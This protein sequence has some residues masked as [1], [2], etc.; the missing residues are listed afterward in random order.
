MLPQQQS[1]NFYKTVSKIIYFIEE[2]AK[3]KIQNDNAPYLKVRTIFKAY[4]QAY[5]G[6]PVHINWVAMAFAI[7]HK[8]GKIKRWSNRVWLWVANGINS[9]DDNNG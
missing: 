4:K 9:G 7:L 2:K 3:E 6:D 1:T 5:P 8:Q